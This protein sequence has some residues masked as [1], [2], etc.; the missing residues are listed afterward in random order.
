MTG[1][2]G[3]PRPAGSH[4]LVPGTVSGHVV[5]A[6]LV[7]GDLHVHSPA[8]RAGVPPPRQIPVPPPHFTDRR[9]EVAAVAAAAAGASTGLVVV[10]GAGGM[11]KTALAT[12]ALGQLAG[13][14]PGGLFYASLG[15]FAAG[16]PAGPVSVLGGWLRAAG[17]SPRAIPA[18]VEEAAAMW[19]SAT[20]TCPVGVLADDAASARQVRALVPAA[21]LAVVT[22]RHRLAELAADGA[23][24]ILLGP[25]PAAAATDLA[26][27]IAGRP[28]DPA[29]LAALASACGGIPLAIAAAAGQAAARP[30]LPLQAIADSLASGRRQVA[31]TTRSPHPEITMSLDSSYDQLD[32][33]T[34]RACRLLALC[35]GPTFTLPTAAALLGTDTGTAA[36]LTGDLVTASLLDE[37]AGGRFRFHDLIR[38]HALDLA[39]QHDGQATQDAAVAAAVDWY[40]LQSA[41]ADLAVMPL[42]LRHAPIYH[43]ARAHPAWPGGAEVALAW[44]ETEQPNLAAAQQAAARLGL[45]TLAWQFGDTMWGQ[46][47]YHHDHGIW[48]SVYGQALASARACGDPLARYMARIRLAMYHRATGQPGQAREHAADA[49]AAAQAIGNRDAQ[50]SACEHTGLAC[51]DDGD[52]AAAAHWSEQGLDLYALAGGNTRGEGLLHRNLGR[53]HTALGNYHRAAGHFAAALDAFTTIGDTHLQAA[54][55]I[56]AAEVHQAQ[57]SPERAVTTLQQALPL[58]TAEASPFLRGRVLTALAA[59]LSD[60][61]DTVTAQTHLTEAARIHGQ[62]RLSPKDPE[63][64]R[65]QALATR[66]GITQPPA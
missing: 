39:H 50:A 18:G 17:I 40:L 37:E 7:S 9:D 21:G 33:G 27:Q 2:E 34:A 22:S 24:L 35:P 66:L 52:P 53:A 62:L 51:L 15:A 20:A 64:S 54:T 63:R 26:A 42:R 38:A 44:L 12:R 1:G 5:Q 45:H 13:R 31:T 28:T 23:R 36:G 46:I 43:R 4:N 61:G 10:C 58:T 60:T 29:A 55:L 11:G 6:G 25:L 8:A 41:R 32:P 65:A 57:G 47:A 49:L 16:G 59:A 3:S 19:R 30:H 48:P 14:F 56:G